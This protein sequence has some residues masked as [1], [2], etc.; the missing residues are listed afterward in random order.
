MQYALLILEIMF[1]SSKTDTLQFQLKMKKDK[2]VWKAQIS[3]KSPK[4][5]IKR[6]KKTACY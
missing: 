3:C 4:Q 1:L 5:I 2:S 6:K